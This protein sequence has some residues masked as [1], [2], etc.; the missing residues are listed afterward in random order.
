[1][2]NPLVEC[3]PNFSEARRPEVVKAITDAIESVPGV[4]IL[5]QHSDLDHNRTVVTM[6]GSPEAIFDASFNAIATAAKLIDLDQ[7]TGAHPRL[8]ATDVVPFVPISDI[9]MLECIELARK[10]GHKVGE[11]LHIPVYLYEEAAAIPTRKNLEDIRRGEYELLKEEIATNP[12][13]KPDFGPSQVSPAGATVIGARHALVAFNAYLSTGDVKIAQNIARAVRFSTGGMRF[14]K[15]LGLLVDGQAQVS[16]NLTNFTKSPVAR[17]IEMIRREAQHYGVMVTHTELVG[18]IPQQ[19]LVDAAAWYLQLDGFS[20]EQ[21]LEQR[22]FKVSQPDAAGK[23]D[24]PD[25]FSFIDA[26]STGDATPGGG[27]AAAFT[28]AE[29]AGLVAMMARL[30]VGRKKYAEH[31]AH[32]WSILDEIIPLKEELKTLTDEDA[33]AFSRIMEAYKLPKETDEQLAFRKAKIEEFMIGATEVPLKVARLAVRIMELAKDVVEVGNLNSISDG[34]A[35]VFLAK[36]AMT[37][38]GLNVQ[39]NLQ[40]IE[41]T[42]LVS[43]YRLQLSKLEEQARAIEAQVRVHLEQRAEMKPL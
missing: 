21:I 5:D 6:I 14:V 42:A 1:M 11:E 22:L 41:D 38:A 18:L 20:T 15:A 27:A 4:Y 10:L 17:V 35:G 23:T 32:M 2:P 19:A 8:G 43:N 25:K 39:I 29:A 13:R 37:A 36:A 40:S 12:E 16:M 28:A 33:V 34:A 30:T 26:L 31:E 9:S 7:H 24:V 3:V